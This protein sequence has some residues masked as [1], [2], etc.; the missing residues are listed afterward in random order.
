MRDAP[1]P[2]E[3]ARWTLLRRRRGGEEQRAFHQA[4]TFEGLVG[5]A[6]D[7]DDSAAEGV[8]IDADEG[9]LLGVLEVREE[10]QLLRRRIRGV[11]ERERGLHRSEAQPGVVHV[12]G[13]VLR[14][15]EVD[16]R[17]D[18]L[19]EGAKLRLRE[20]R[21]ARCARNRARGVLNRLVH[22]AEPGRLARARI[23]P[24]FD[25]DARSDLD[26]TLQLGAAEGE[27]ARRHLVL[28]KVRRRV[29]EDLCI[30]RVQVE[31]LAEF[32]A[33]PREAHA[34]LGPRVHRPPRELLHRDLR[35]D[36]RVGVVRLRHQRHLDVHQVREALILRCALRRLL[37][38]ERRG[39]RRL[40]RL[41]V[42]GV[43]ST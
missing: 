14:E 25:A 2:G 5:E 33:Q 16:V 32:A 41:G 39:G 40:S 17:K 31:R 43:R 3:A 26:A 34:R 28:P 37:L 23:A 10:P 29:R 1:P 9:L 18:A 36:E 24:A 20:L 13:L 15:R 21:H 35:V 22:M 19:H 4:R 6:R 12:D 30:L 11:R 27:H 38:S 8:P 42:D 7:G